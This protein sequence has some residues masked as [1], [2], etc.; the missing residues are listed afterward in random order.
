M[1]IY[2]AP[3]MICPQIS[4]WEDNKWIWHITH[5]HTVAY[6]HM[7]VCRSQSVYML[8]ACIAV[9]VSCSDPHIT[10]IAY[11][12][13]CANCAWW[14]CMAAAECVYVCQCVAVSFLPLCWG[15]SL[16]LFLSPAS[17]AVGTA[18]A[19]A[20]VWAARRLPLSPHQNPSLLSSRAACLRCSWFS[21]SCSSWS[22]G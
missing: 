22:C 5:T 1:M 7:H 4:V 10:H 9:T 8:F 15:T 17:L 6:E 16:S 14:L 21:A 13:V 20:L 19:A 11:L 12:C 18:A 2:K 3:L